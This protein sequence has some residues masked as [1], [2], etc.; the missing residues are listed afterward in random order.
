MKSS[1]LLARIA[2]MTLITG[3][4]VVALILLATYAST[5]SAQ[6]TMMGISGSSQEA[7]SG[8]VS[9]SAPLMHRVMQSAIA[10]DDAATEIIAPTAP[11]QRII[12]TASLD[13]ETNSALETVDTLSA[14][15]SAHQGFIQS[16]SV[17]EDTAG[18]H[19]AFVILRVPS[20]A[21]GEV[22]LAIKNLANRLN[23]ETVTGEDVT[24]H[25]TDIA[26]RLTAAQEQEAQYLEILDEAKTVEDILAVQ[27]YLASV[28]S[29]IEAYQ[30]QIAYLEN[31]TSLATI[32][33]TVHESP[34]TSLPDTNK[35]DLV[36]DAHAALALVITFGQKALSV[37]VWVLIISFAIGIPVGIAAGFVRLVSKRRQPQLP[38]RR[39]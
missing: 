22:M 18:N 4:T 16:S 29:D 2:Q 11:E 25:Y 9:T 31:R 3:L 24:E 21:F 33:V 19:E 10:N 23:T 37:L 1:S 27:A 28:R 8:N 6:N 30:G 34:K 26:A 17:A 32:T 39:R 15:A 7:S 36:H 5:M 13:I 38:T 12:K 20:S 14:L 35:F